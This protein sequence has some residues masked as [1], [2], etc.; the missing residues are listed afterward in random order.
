MQ[1]LLSGSLDH[2]SCSKFT[3]NSLYFLSHLPNLFNTS[4]ADI[5]NA[6]T[7]FYSTTLLTHKLE[8]ILTPNLS[9]SKLPVS[10]H[11]GWSQTRSE[12]LSPAQLQNECAPKIQ[13]NEGLWEKLHHKTKPRDSATGQESARWAHSGT[14][15]RRC[16]KDGI[17]QSLKVP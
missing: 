11:A 5:K 2:W 15:E 1:T 4:F 13:S 9:S 3:S 14:P 16:S 12:E 6:I 17:S 7:S 8:V 10:A